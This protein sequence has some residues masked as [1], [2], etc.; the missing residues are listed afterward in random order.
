MNNIYQRAK[1]CGFAVILAAGLSGAAMA[2]STA[3]NPNRTSGAGN[4]GAMTSNSASVSQN[5]STAVK[6][7]QRKLK[8]DGFYTGRIDGIDGPETHAAVRQYQKSESIDQTGKLDDATLNS[9][10]I[11]QTGN[12]GEANRSQESSGAN[13]GTTGKTQSGHTRQQ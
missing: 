6:Q 13:S 4:S 5:N 7:A 10:G 2:Q 3:I 12:Q 1:Y 9:L 8:Q 11:A